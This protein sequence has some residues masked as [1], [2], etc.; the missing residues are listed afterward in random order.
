MRSE[1]QKI[2]KQLAAIESQV[3]VHEYTFENIAEHL[4]EALELIED[5]G[6]TY[7]MVD[8]HIKRMLNQAIFTK[9]WVESDGRITPELREPFNVLVAPLADVLS[10]YKQEQEKARGTE[11]LTD[12]FSRFSKYLQNFFGGG[13]SNDLMVEIS[14]IEPLTA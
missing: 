1:Q 13:W 10:L 5:C 3:K 2:A 14:G 8:D 9:L 11:V 6:K 4:S 7:R 12:I